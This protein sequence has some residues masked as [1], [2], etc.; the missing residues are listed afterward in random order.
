MN[1]FKHSQPIEYVL[2]CVKDGI[3][4]DQFDILNALTQWNTIKNREPAA[5]ATDYGDGV[6][7]NFSQEKDPKREPYTTIILY[8][9]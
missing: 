7:R 9:G 2:R 8:R 6:L 5:Y 4:V 1:N 3:E